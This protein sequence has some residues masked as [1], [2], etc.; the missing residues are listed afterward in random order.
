M[1]SVWSLYNIGTCCHVIAQVVFWVELPVQRR[2]CPISLNHGSREK[3]TQWCSVRVPD[4]HGFLQVDGLSLTPGILGFTIEA[5]GKPDKGR[6]RRMTPYNED[7]FSSS[8]MSMSIGTQFSDTSN[9]DNIFP[10][11]TMSY[12]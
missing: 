8:S 1:D 9:E 10:P 11:Y 3:G 6:Q 4:I 5:I 2:L 12:G 7:S